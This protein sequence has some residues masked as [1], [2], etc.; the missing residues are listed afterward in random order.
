MT[1]GLW[2]ELKIYLQDVQG[3]VLSFK[4]GVPVVPSLAEGE[5]MIPS[6]S[7]LRTGPS[8]YL[9]LL[10]KDG[11]VLEAKIRVYPNSTIAIEEGLP[12]YQRE[13][14]GRVFRGQVDAQVIT[15]EDYGF[16]LN[17]GTT[18]ARFTDPGRLK[19]FL[20]PGESQILHSQRGQYVVTYRNEDAY[21]QSGK[22]YFLSAGGNYSL[23]SLSATQMALFIRRQSFQVQEEILKGGSSS[24]ESYLEDY[25]T[26]AP[27]FLKALGELEEDPIIKKWASQ[28][29]RSSIAEATKERIGLAK[30][31]NTLRSL[32]SPLEESYYALEGL[33]PLL[34]GRGVPLGDQQKEVASFKRQQ[35]ILLGALAQGEF[36]LG[37]L[38][39]ID[40][41]ASGGILF[42]SREAVQELLEKATP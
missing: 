24:L 17:T 38:H 34:E 15:L 30:K 31:S 20:Y 33:I 32:L 25:K 27:K 10:L 39:R 5:L 1:G 35:K 26:L 28:N 21:I 19:I 8:G 36:Y 18:V 29:Q 12:I 42:P 37:I 41:R 22:A 11:E 14:V 3:E 23:H 7:L 4:G 6:Y 40:K 16:T 13:L 9:T 2:G